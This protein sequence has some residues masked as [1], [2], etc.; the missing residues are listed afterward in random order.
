MKITASA[1]HFTGYMPDIYVELVSIQE[2]FRPMYSIK[3]PTQPI[4]GYFYSFSNTFRE[5]VKFLQIL[6]RQDHK[7][8]SAKSSKNQGIRQWFEGKG[9]PFLISHAWNNIESRCLT[10]LVITFIAKMGF[11]DLT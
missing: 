3:E 1:F 4:L 6:A 11:T 8:S 9:R 2:Y 10:A 7:A 5:N